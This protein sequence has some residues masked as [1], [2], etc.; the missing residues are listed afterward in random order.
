MISFCLAGI[1]VWWR[2]P[3]LGSAPAAC[4]A[5]VVVSRVQLLCHGKGQFAGARVLLAGHRLNVNVASARDLAHM[6]HVSKAL[7]QR[8]VQHRQQHGPLQHLQQL[9]AIKGVG[10]ATLQK[11]APFLTAEP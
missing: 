4:L 8:I 10:K 6:P 1:G 2:V 11:L 5:P 7:A 9:Q 3:T